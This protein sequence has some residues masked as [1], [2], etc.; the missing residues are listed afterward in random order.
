LKG[1]AKTF[2]ALGSKRSMSKEKSD[3]IFEEL[4]KATLSHKR[5]LQ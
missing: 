1:W 2:E 3:A 4:K 5:T